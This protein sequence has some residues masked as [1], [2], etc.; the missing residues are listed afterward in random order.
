MNLR[1]IIDAICFVAASLNF[2]YT[3]SCCEFLNLKIFENR[4]YITVGKRSDFR[5]FFR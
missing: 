4:S 2:I 5:V 1:F 3:V